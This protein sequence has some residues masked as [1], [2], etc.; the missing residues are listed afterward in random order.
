[1]RTWNHFALELICGDYSLCACDDGNF[2][3]KM[4]RVCKG[5]TEGKKRDEKV[6]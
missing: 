5:L 6:E 2:A 3:E 4:T 1:M